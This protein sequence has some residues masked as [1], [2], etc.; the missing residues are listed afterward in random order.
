M[1]LA[2]GFAFAAGVAT[3]FAPC[4]F[5]L[6]PGYVAYYLGQ[7]SV[8]RGPVARLQRAALVGGLTSVGF[9]LVY[10]LLAGIVAALGAG[11]L[12]DVALLEPV[13]G[14]L[15]IGLGVATAAGYSVGGHVPL[16]ERRRS[17][18]GFLLFGVVY[19]AAAAG[20]TAPVFVGVALVAL[21]GTPATAVVTLGAYAAGMAATMLAVTVLSALGRDRA[22]QLLSRSTGRLARV[23]GGL[24]A[25]A[26]VAQIYLWYFDFDPLGGL[27]ALGLL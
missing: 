6:L 27:R 18:G 17:L 12:R 9:L 14:A 22:L 8:D 25:L 5:P 20:C 3:F 2:P 15:L 24:L 11:A 16:P 26:G 1:N 4:A 10:G 19:A 13:V 23:S 7:D 21:S